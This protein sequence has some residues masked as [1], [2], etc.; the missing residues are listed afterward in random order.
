MA[1]DDPRIIAAYQ[2][3]LGRCECTADHADT[4][5]TLAHDGRCTK[6]FL[7]REYWRAFESPDGALIYC[8]TCN[9]AATT[10]AAAGTGAPA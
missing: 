2:R 3:S 10:N 4:P 9:R 8:I 1:L 5:N 7:G 6:T